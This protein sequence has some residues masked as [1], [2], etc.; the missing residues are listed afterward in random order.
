MPLNAFLKIEGETSGE[1]KGSCTAAGQEGKMEIVSWSH[2]FSQPMTGAAESAFGGSATSR[3]TH[4][5]IN[6]TKYFDSASDEILK[7]CW[8]G[9]Q[10]KTCQLQIFRSDGNTSYG[11]SSTPYLV[12][13]LEKA[14]VADYQIAGNGQDIPQEHIALAY[15]KVKYTF[16]ATDA[17]GAPAE[18]VPI[19]CDLATNVV[20]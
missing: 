8:T 10:L 18:Q 5:N 16:T 4:A 7:A 15:K 20:A 3:A 6:L 1:W 12:I 11:D 14:Y 17:T 2:G 9:E 13:D 19:S